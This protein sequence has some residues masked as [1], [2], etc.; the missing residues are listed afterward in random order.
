MGDNMNI[1]DVINKKRN[2]EKLSFDELKYVIDGYV[3]DEIKD[4]LEAVQGVIGI[5]QWVLGS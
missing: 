5:N 2:G 4:S 3:K 1:I